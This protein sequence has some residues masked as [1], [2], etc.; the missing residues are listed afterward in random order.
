M[1]KNELSSAYRLIAELFLHPEERDR[2]LIAAELARLEKAPGALK[3]SLGAFFDEPRSTDVDEYVSTLELTP[4]VPLYLGAHLFEEPGSCRGAGMSGRNGYMLE[5]SNIY[6]HFGVESA[7]RE[8]SDFVPVIVDFLALSLDR[9]DLDRIGLRRYLVESLV[10]N[11]VECLL[12]ALRKYE[13]PYV[14]LIE[15][16]RVALTEDVADLAGG[17]KWAPPADGD[18]PLVP[19]KLSAR[20]KAERARQEIGVEL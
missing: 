20:T 2:G 4:A 12:S 15:A 13:S 17:P 9:A 16:L 11:G 8:L 3:A 7:G 10:L 18:K 5:L 1:D 19:A 14:H 6:R